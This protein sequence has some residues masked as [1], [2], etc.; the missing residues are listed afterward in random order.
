[1]KKEKVCSAKSGFTAGGIRDRLLLEEE[2]QEQGW[3]LLQ[4]VQEGEDG[5][6]GGGGWTEQRIRLVSAPGERKPA[7]Q[8]F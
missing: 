5:G 3:K 8:Q 6:G 2:K 1:M 4:V 7:L